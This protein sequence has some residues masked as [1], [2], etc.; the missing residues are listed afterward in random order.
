M[1][2]SSADRE[3]FAR[4]RRLVLFDLDDTLYP[5][6]TYLDAGYA[7][8]GEALARQ[9]PKIDAAHVAAHLQKRFRLFG[10]QRLFQDVCTQFDLP[11]AAVQTMMDALR[12]VQVPWGLEIVP[13]MAD[14]LRR[15]RERRIPIAIVTNGNLEQ[16]VNKVSQ[17]RPKALVDDVAVYY[18]ARYRPKP[19]P[20]AIAAALADH[21]V[22]S[23]EAVFVGDGV[24]D[25]QA[26]AAAQVEFVHVRSFW[27]AP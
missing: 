24:V 18:C 26:A 4:D 8:C 10:R 27:S 23:N 16:Q 5:E 25:E 13:P 2:S 9:H 17:L 19:Y 3:T 22:A 21:G 11:T 14:L 7:A 1:T 15:L 12:S 20:D 6:I